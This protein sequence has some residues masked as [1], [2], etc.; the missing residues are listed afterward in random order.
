MPQPIRIALES[1]LWLFSLRDMFWKCLAFAALLTAL[2]GCSTVQEIG[3]RPPA[4]PL[5]A[6]Q[7]RAAQ[8]HAVVTLPQFETTP[9]AVKATVD[10]TIAAGN[11][12]LDGI[13]QFH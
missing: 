11:T 8:Y 7:Q 12:A 2:A 9:D 3:S 1:S 10:Q 4:D 13:G 6:F 5:A